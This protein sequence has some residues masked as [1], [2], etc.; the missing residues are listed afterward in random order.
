[1]NLAHIFVAALLAL[2]LLAFQRGSSQHRPWASLL[3]YL[4]IVAAGAVAVL[5]LFGRHELAELPQLFIN[6]ALL[7]ALIAQRGNV[8]ELFRNSGPRQSRLALLLRKE[9]WL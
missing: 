6:L 4:L 1:M 9:T 7:L 8:V 5:R 2:V 3:A